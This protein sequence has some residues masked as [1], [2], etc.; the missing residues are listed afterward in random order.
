MCMHYVCIMGYKIPI[1]PV[2]PRQMWTLADFSCGATPAGDFRQG[3]TMRSLGVSNLRNI[4]YGK[5]IKLGPILLCREKFYCID[6][7]R[8]FTFF[9]FLLIII[10]S[11]LQRIHG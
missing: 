4:L 5:M 8:V 3:F 2:H 11:V 9:S 6:S 10:L 1:S 7:A